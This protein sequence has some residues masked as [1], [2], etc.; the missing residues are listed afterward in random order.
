[1]ADPR[2]LKLHAEFGVQTFG[3]PVPVPVGHAVLESEGS[4]GIMMTMPEGN[5]KKYKDAVK[6]LGPTD[7]AT[8]V[9][10]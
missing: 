3:S 4:T 9:M 8:M 7:P 1:M 10:R 5:L 2:I 6:A